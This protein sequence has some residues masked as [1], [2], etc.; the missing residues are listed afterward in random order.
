M[1]LRMDQPDAEIPR[2]P[3]LRANI[4]SSG[5]WNPAVPA[6]RQSIASTLA[7]EC[8]PGAISY[9]NLEQDL[10]WGL[11]GFMTTGKGPM[12]V[13]RRPLSNQMNTAMDPANPW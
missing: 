5:A 11:E 9:A 7:F 4:G 6:N 12:A 8:Y 1:A 2:A 13:Y 3:T 10:P